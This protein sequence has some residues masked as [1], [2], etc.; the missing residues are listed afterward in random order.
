M[1]LRS[2]RP[3]D[4]HPAP[5]IS[6]ANDAAEGAPSEEETDEEPEPQLSYWQMVKLGYQVSLR[7]LTQRVLINFAGISKRNYKT[8]TLRL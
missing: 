7:H 5:P 6:N 2:S 8:A 3:E 4:N 1:G